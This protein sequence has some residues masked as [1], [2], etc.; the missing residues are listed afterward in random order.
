MSDFELL[1]GKGE[2]IKYALIAKP[3][4][5]KE[6]EEKQISLALIKDAVDI[7]LEICKK[8]FR[9]KAERKFLNFGHTFGHAI[10]S[11]LYS[12]RKVSHGHCVA[13]GM[14]VALECSSLLSL[15]PENKAEEAINFIA[16]QFDFIALDQQELASAMNI[17]MQD[18]KN[19]SGKIMMVLLTDF[20]TAVYDVEVQAELISK[21][22]LNLKAKY[23]LS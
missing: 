16:E 21:A 3:E 12:T 15:L 1:S 8:D 22:Y 6:L 2:L 4:M 20:G 10:E 23:Q 7:K 11:L 18:K 19:Q 5:L 13:I 14:M 9:E 17:L